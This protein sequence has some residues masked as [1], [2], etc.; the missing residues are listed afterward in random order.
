[1][2]SHLFQSVPLTAEQKK[3]AAQERLIIDVASMVWGRNKQRGYTLEEL[4][5]RLGSKK[6]H[7]SRLLSG[8]SNITLRTLSDLAL[9]LDCQ[10][11]FSLIPQ[12]SSQEQF[13]PYKPNEMLYLP[14]FK[15]RQTTFSNSEMIL[16]TKKVA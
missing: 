13:Q 4:A 10:P 9:A 7:V 12:W 16:E 6:A 2:R 3:I 1:M 11:N 5:R 15:A 8:D 14:K